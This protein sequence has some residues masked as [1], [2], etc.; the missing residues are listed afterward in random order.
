MV[1]L[2]ERLEAEIVAGG[3]A[4]AG[5][6]EEELAVFTQQVHNPDYIQEYMEGKGNDDVEME[7][8]TTSKE[9]GSD[10]EDSDDDLLV[11]ISDDEDEDDEMTE[12]DR[13]FVTDN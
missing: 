13:A 2:V 4:G 5:V 10:T 1:P 11:L 12:E 9:E 6:L 7:E 8:G 3:S